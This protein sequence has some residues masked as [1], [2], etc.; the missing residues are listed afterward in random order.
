M[1]YAI[2]LDNGGT[3]IKAA[4]FDT[5]GQ[6]IAVCSMQTPVIT[7]KPGYTERD[8]EDLWINNCH[9][10]HDVIQK[11]GINPKDIVG[12]AVCGHG[13][14]L[15]PWGKNQKPAYHGIVSTDSRGWQYPE[16]W[17]AD[18]TWEKLYPQICQKFM[19]CQQV[20]LLAWFK[21]HEREVYDNI[22]WV[23]S[24]KDYIRFRLT[25]EAY[26]EATDISGSGLMDIKNAC[27]DRNLLKELGIEE[28]YEKLAPIRYSYEL[29]G[30][31]TEDAAKLTG[32]LPGTT[33]AGGMFDIDASA[34]GMDI[35]ST[36]DI[37]TIAGTW[38]INEFISKTPITDG[39]ISMNSLYAI[40]GYYL[41]E[42]CSATS[43]GNLEWFIK[44]CMGNEILPD[45]Q[46]IYDVINEKVSSVE[47]QLSD[48]YFLPFLYGSNA[49]P[50]GK[51][52][53]IGLTTYHTNAHMLRSI[54][55]GVVYSH[56][57]HIDRLLSARQT[58]RSV[59]MAGGAVNSKVWVQMFAD[60]L[61][62]PV[63]TVKVKEIG[64]LGCAMAAFVA[65]GIYENY[66]AAAQVMVHISEKVLPNPE[67]TKIYEGKFEKY[68]AINHALNTVW[69][70]FEV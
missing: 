52:A 25:G 30:R 35:T 59:R 65:A 41:I 4:V 58:P 23:F 8:M 42:E 62:L 2:G 5:K 6:E 21:E 13:K 66:E 19:A 1:E 68:M 57:T 47:P 55:E 69:D 38:S 48:V 17:E 18:G 45:G 12:V 70:Q 27:F 40:P 54:F 56:K 44:N 10:I 14:G 3:V 7:P 43:A 28:V 49:H 64:A 29:C 26:S 50:L 36:E 51:G 67:M 46:N 20:S 11:A 22:E 9:C 60:V 61:G 33:V 32:L 37:C 31:I 34:I 53:F 15:Y 39:S 24:V 16:K 63:E